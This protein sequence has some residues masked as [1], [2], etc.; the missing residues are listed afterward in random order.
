MLRFAAQQNSDRDLAIDE[1]AVIDPVL[2]PIFDP[3]PVVAEETYG[4]VRGR[5][6]QPHAAWATPPIAHDL[7]VNPMV[8]PFPFWTEE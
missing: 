3:T 4:F 5:I 6:R 7:K 8:H 2:H 1:V